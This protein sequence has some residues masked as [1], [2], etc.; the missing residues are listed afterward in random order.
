M[1]RTPLIATIAAGLLLAGLP[2]AF[3]AA[4]PS[5]ASCT[6]WSFNGGTAIDGI[7]FVFTG[8]TIDHYIQASRLPGDSHAT[9][10]GILSGGISGDQLQ[11][12]Y[13]PQ[14]GRGL[15]VQGHVNPDG[16]AQ[17]TDDQGGTWQMDETPLKCLTTTATASPSA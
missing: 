10:V 2:P 11:L 17:G 3:A 8:P 4:A 12:T 7:A 1:N 6:Q 9:P 15:K 5:T 16:Y 14:G 13:V